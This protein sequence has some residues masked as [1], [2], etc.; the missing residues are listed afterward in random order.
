MAAPASHSEAEGLSCPEAFVCPITLQCMTDPATTADGHS[1]ERSAIANWLQQRSAAPTSPLTGMLLPSLGL[2]PNHALRHAIEKW[3]AETRGDG[4]AASRRT[5]SAA[6]EPSTPDLNTP[7]DATIIHAAPP[8]PASTASPPSQQPGAI[9]A[10]RNWVRLLAD[11]AQRGSIALVAAV[12]DESEHPTPRPEEG[13]L[14]GSPA[15]GAMAVLASSAVARRRSLLS[16]GAADV[17]LQQ[18]ASHG[19]HA[20]VVEAS[21]RAFVA[22]MAPSPEGMPV[23]VFSPDLL[24]DIS[25]SLTGAISRHATHPGACAAAASALANVTATE[26]DAGRVAAF[27][28]GAVAT[29]SAALT[30]HQA[31]ILAHDTLATTCGGALAGALSN[32]CAA[33]AMHSGLTLT[34]LAVEEL[35]RSD[36]VPLLLRCLRAMEAAPQ[37][38]QRAQAEVGFLRLGRSLTRSNAAARL[39]IAMHD[40]FPVLVRFARRQDGDADLIA[41]QVMANSLCGASADVARAALN[42]SVLE[43]AATCGK[44]AAAA[45]TQRQ[46]PG[47]ER[48]LACAAILARLVGACASDHAAGGGHTLRLRASRCDAAHTLR[49]TMRALP[50]DMRAQATTALAIIG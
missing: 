9:A 2:T 23:A 8:T 5:R 4:A 41:L 39:A 48:K 24:H 42:A 34:A 15:A 18:L 13:G 40:G 49:D 11:T 12:A 3:L 27:E 33:G 32:I 6:P 17:L 16:H 25:R 14:V 26:H 7:R 50:H 29:C 10:Q 28:A 31:A 37:S 44:A 46:A 1:Y 45:E 36:T 38:P 43:T 47:M 21:C 22:L 35:V 20:C 19:T 30:R